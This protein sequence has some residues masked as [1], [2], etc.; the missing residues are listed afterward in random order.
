M[1][2]DKADL[3]AVAKEKYFCRG[4]L[5]DPNHVDPAQQIRV[6]AQAEKARR[7]G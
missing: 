2:K 3:G 5:D 7:V 1:V 4:G 6:Y